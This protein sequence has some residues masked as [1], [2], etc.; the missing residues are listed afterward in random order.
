MMRRL[1]SRNG[2]SIL[3]YVL[4]LGVVVAAILIMQVWVKRGFQGGMKDAGD[5]MGDQ[6]SAGNTSISKNTTMTGDQT[7][8]DETATK[9]GTAI[10]Q[11]QAD[12]TD[13]VGKGA[14]TVSGRSGGETAQETKQQTDASAKEKFKWTE[15]DTTE[16]E[17]FGAPF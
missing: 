16:H 3:E 15:Y 11:Y 10:A 17:N 6:F 2:Q 8:T 13:A 5:K 1:R 12:Q 4:L 14:F 7:I 9:A